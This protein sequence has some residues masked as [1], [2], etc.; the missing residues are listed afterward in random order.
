MKYPFR[1]HVLV[2]T[3]ARCNDEQRG[4]E[5]GEV[6]QEELKALNKAL[7]RKPTV[8]VCRV[9]CLDLCDEGPNMVIYPEGRLFCGLDRERA[10][11][12][13]FEIVGNPDEE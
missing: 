12:A 11:A 7:G 8:R 6:I 4:I 1:R 10:R 3:G 2:C 13:Y 5:R 9:S